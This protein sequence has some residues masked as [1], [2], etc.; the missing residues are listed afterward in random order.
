MKKSF[1]HSSPTF[2]AR[3]L[4]VDDEANIR[5]ALS[6]A[7]SLLGYTVEEAGS[8]HEALS[9]LENS[10]YDLMVLDMV[11]PDVD[12]MAVMDHARRMYP[13]LL[14]IILTG[15]ATLE[16]AIAAV[17]S[18][19]IDYL[20]KP[21]SLQEIANTVTQ[22]LQKRAD[23]IQR[24]HLVEVMGEALEALRQGETRPLSTLTT[25]LESH[26]LLQIHPLT[27]DRQKRMVAIMAD[28]TYM[29]Q[30]TEG[31]TAVLAS[32]MIH[33]DQV[34]SCSDL[35]YTAWGY[36]MNEREAQS[37]IR[38]YICRLR[39]KI[40]SLFK[41]RLIRTVRKRGYVFLVHKQ[42]T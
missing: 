19:A 24:Q 8:G 26:N 42:P 21:A 13:D 34:L 31:E 38:P 14:I 20:L 10:A 23:Q 2:G 27:L 28:Q 33:S 32:L 25:D 37:V 40:E 9:L 16:S 4:V 7:L 36:T 3:L 5:S 17:K 11:M 6:R 18:K 22:A 41:T 29:L 15:H 1:T 12:G 30:L 39:T 35:I